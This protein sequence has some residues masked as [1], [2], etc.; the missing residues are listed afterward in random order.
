MGIRAY[1]ILRQEVETTPTFTINDNEEIHQ[2]LK[3]LNSETEVTVF[4]INKEILEK[5]KRAAKQYETLETL[6]EIERVL[7]FSNKEFLEF[8]CK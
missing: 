4:I 1:R 5:A 2:I 7:M 6:V 3:S 8:V